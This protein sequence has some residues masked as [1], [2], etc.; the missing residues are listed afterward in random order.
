MQQKKSLT[1]FFLYENFV[2]FFYN[3]IKLCIFDLDCILK[4][5]THKNLA[6]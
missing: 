5:L 6:F 4:L 2:C 1:V 3:K